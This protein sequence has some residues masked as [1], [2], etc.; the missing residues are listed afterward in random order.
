MKRIVIYQSSTGFT[1]KY[2]QWIAGE[3]NCKAVG[4]KEINASE[5]AAFDQVIFGGWIM[6]NM[7]TG[8]RKIQKMNPKNL[9]TFA[10]GA[11]PDYEEVVE[12]IVEQNELK[13]PFFY[14]Q[15][16]L[17]YDKLSLPSK[18]ILSTV[19]KTVEKKTDKSRAEDYI[20]KMIGQ[21]FDAS[22]SDKIKE[23]I[24]T[25]KSYE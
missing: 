23:L 22:S 21:S 9:I 8:I 1:K 6:G 18:L 17:D 13:S 24:N 20:T 15:G 4:I 11:C 14:F 10:V 7:I 2:A 16:G 25:V 3:L 5:I 19:K 12:G